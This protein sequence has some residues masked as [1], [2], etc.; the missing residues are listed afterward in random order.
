MKDKDLQQNVI[1][2]LNW[3][4]SVNAANIGVAA[5][6]GVITLTGTVSSY[7][8]KDSAESAAGRVYGVKG[9][10]DELKVVYPLDQR[11]DDASVAKRAL[12]V[13]SWDAMVPLTV[14]V[15]VDGG[16][17]TLSGEVSWNYQK[18]A[19]EYDVQKLSGVVGVT[20]EITI[21]PTV[22]ASA[23]KEK[24]VGALGRNA[25]IEADNI[26]VTA[27]GGKVTL[28]GDVDTWY[29][30]DL[31]ETTAWSAPGVTQVSNELSVI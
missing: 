1:D 17:L 26:I 12:Q 8:E 15:G 6:D 27:D 28:A 18:D 11:L 16:W 20:N 23:V 3:E 30:R 22:Q 14:K 4:P 13:L 7:A 9:I 10:A 31:A 24:I 29:E 5:S 19:A 2:E 21:R 25:Q